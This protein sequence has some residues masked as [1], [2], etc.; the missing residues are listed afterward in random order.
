[1]VSIGRPF[2][3]GT[4]VPNQP[5]SRSHA[6]SSSTGRSPSISGISPRR[7]LRQV[8]AALLAAQL[9]EQARVAVGRRVGRPGQ[10][11]DLL[12]SHLVPLRL[13][14]PAALVAGIESHVEL[15]VGTVGPALPADPLS[16]VP[17]D[18]GRGG[19][20]V[21]YSPFTPVR[22]GSAVSGRLSRPLPL[23]AAG[24]LPACVAAGQLVEAGTAAGSGATPP[25]RG[26]HRDGAALGQRMRGR[27][28]FATPTC[29]S[30]TPSGSRGRWP[31]PARR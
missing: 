31:R 6:F 20:T 14:G 1:M 5:C 18:V 8:V 15:V 30:G 19:V 7:P 22:S 4:C 9:G 26:R 16:P 13:V 3:F 27:A 29:R 21:A 24:R 11:G 10:P 17:A 2:R 25:R 12:V 28:C 23:I